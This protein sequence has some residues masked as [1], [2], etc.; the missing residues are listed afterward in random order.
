MGEALTDAGEVL[1]RQIHPTFVED[2]GE[3]SSQPF[4]PSKK[5]NNMLSV[6]RSSLTDVASSHA[7]YIANGQASIAVYGIT[8]DEFDKEKL[9]CTAD[10]LEKTEKLAANPAHALA[11]YAAF[12]AGQQKTIAKRLKIVA[13]ARGVLFPR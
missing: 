1:F 2:D 4:I 7:L 10:P 3:P 8:V 13:R 5:D 6:D 11:N 12:S 9:P